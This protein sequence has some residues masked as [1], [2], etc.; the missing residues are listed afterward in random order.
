MKILKRIIQFLVVITLFLNTI[1]TYGVVEEATSKNSHVVYAAKKKKPIQVH[2]KK[3]TVKSKKKLKKRIQKKTR[4]NQI[5]WANIYI[6]IPKNSNDYR[7]TRKAI[8]EW[9]ATKVIKFNLVTNLSRAAIIVQHGQY[10]ET[11]WAGL[12]EIKKNRATVRLNDYILDRVNDYI[13]MCI[14]EHELGHTIGLEH[15]DNE[16]SV[17]NSVLDPDTVSDIQPVDIAN[18]KK[19]YS[20]K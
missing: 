6:D 3:N 9:N 8:N 5:P 7:I 11:G 4:K 10:G 1:D 19:I 15:N 20:L 2:K 12:T 14:A 16:K 17:M 13:A 18:V